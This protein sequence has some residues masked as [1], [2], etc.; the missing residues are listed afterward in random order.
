MPEL[1]SPVVP[2]GRLRDRVQP[3]LT[4]DEL[5]LRPWRPPDADR[6]VEAYGD[7]DI[8]Q[9]HARSMTDGEARGW[10]ASRAERWQAETGADWAVLDDDGEVIGRAAL[11]TLDLSDG[12]G[13]VAYW[14]VPAAR[15]RDV[16]SRALRAVT[17][18]MFAE[19][20][21]H[22]IELLHSTGNEASCRVAT[23]AGYDVEGTKR[24]QALHADGWHDMHLHA[25]ISEDGD[26]REVPAA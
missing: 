16:A 4:V 25:C 11:R 7:P 17:G 15:G 13:E 2:E 1:V 24:R 9:W 23:K 5:V 26:R 6:L 22:R 20:G 10:I 18:W 14:V 12:S 21:L 19:I 8:R 3:T